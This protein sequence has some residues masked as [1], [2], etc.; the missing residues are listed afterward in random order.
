MATAHKRTPGP[1]AVGAGGSENVH[2]GTLLNGSQTNP[3][4]L[5]LQVSQ[6]QQRFGLTE[7]CA[8]LVAR[9][10]FGEGGAA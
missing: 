9:L 4:P 8:R 3:S 1:M 7:R 5:L 2:A 6:L 10:A